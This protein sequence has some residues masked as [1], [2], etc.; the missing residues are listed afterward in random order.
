MGWGPN[1]K[2]VN[3]KK[4]FNHKEKSPKESGYGKGATKGVRLVRLG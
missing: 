3:A 2:N 1:N 4:C